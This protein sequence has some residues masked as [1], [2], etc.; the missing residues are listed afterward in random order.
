MTGFDMVYDQSVQNV[1]LG[2]HNYV[3]IVLA[4]LEAPTTSHRGRASGSFHVAVTSI[5]DGLKLLIEIV[6]DLRG[7]S[8]NGD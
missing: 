7:Q 6:E 4:A 2:L 1:R 8:A 3:R 5:S